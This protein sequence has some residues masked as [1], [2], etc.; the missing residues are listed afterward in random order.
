MTN[1]FVILNQIT[2]QIEEQGDYEVVIHWLLAPGVL[3]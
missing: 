2:Y 1:R 3:T